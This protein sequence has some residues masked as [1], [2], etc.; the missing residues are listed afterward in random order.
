MIENNNIKS[1]TNREQTNLEINR[2]VVESYT[3]TRK[4]KNKNEIEN[5]TNNNLKNKV[6]IINNL[7]NK[8]NNGNEQEN[9]INNESSNN[10]NQNQNANI[11]K[12]IPSYSLCS[13][14]NLTLT[15]HIKSFDL[16]LSIN[17]STLNY[18]IS[19]PKKESIDNLEVKEIIEIKEKSEI[20]KSVEKLENNENKENKEKNSFRKTLTISSSCIF[21]GGGQNLKGMRIHLTNHK[22]NIAH[23]EITDFKINKN[24]PVEKVEINLSESKNNNN[25]LSNYLE[26]MQKRWKEAEKE[27]KMR[28]TYISNNETITINKKKIFR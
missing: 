8:D 4:N 11:V 2:V 23:K 6:N 20:K 28:L 25:N 21:I 9:E 24:K 3:S 10:Q 1:A 15:S 22:N 7:K 18:L 19:H 17:N 5:N 14:T 12:N 16:P 26:E 27:Y 13:Q